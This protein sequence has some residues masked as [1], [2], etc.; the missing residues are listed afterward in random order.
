M[1]CAGAAIYGDLGML[2]WLRSN[3]AP[4]NTN[5]CAFA[6]LNGH[7]EV[8]Q[9]ARSEGCPWDKYTAHFANQGGRLITDVRARGDSESPQVF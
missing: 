5:T 3:G 1:V 7:L 4:W 6:A 8:L 2:L 9:W